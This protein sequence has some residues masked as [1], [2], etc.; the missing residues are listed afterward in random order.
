M[1]TRGK[2]LNALSLGDAT[3]RHLGADVGRTRQQVF[4]LGAVIVG[5]VTAVA[6]PIGFVG[7]LVPH[8]LRLILGPDHRLLLPA[9]AFGGAIFLLLAG[10]LARMAFPLT[11]SQVP[12][13]VVTACMGG[14]F[15]LWL[16]KKRGRLYG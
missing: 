6:G 15:F 10:S 5:A 14:P 16:L 3:A 4:V 9:S 1:I 13:G 2:M 12:V 8:L 7:L 11:H